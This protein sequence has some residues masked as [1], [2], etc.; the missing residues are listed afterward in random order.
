MF[1]TSAHLAAR[2]DPL[3][4]TSEANDPGEK[5]AESDVPLDLANVT[6]VGESEGHLLSVNSLGGERR[7][8]NALDDLPEELSGSSLA[9]VPLGN[10]ITLIQKASIADVAS[11]V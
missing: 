1:D 9:V 10:V 2:F 11:L 7:L 4:Q 8:V 3:D 6:Q 5:E